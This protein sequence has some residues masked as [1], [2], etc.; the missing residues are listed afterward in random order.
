MGGCSCANRRTSLKLATSR[1]P[2]PAAP[3]AA[4]SPASRPA[5]TAQQ[6]AG[7]PPLRGGAVSRRPRRQPA[8]GPGGPRP[9]G[10]RATSSSE[11]GF[12]AWY[13]LIQKLWRLSRLQLLSHSIP[14]FLDDKLTNEFQRRL[15]EQY[16]VRRRFLR[17][18]PLT[19]AEGEESLTRLLQGEDE[20]EVL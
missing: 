7:R 17:R 9:Q 4:D 12:V 19:E 16:Y 8:T 11:R 3:S 14:R 13:R 18:P 15:F 2:L 5:V 20:Q 6:A 10:G 1:Y